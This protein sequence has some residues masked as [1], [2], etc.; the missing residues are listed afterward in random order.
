MS[1]AC[2]ALIADHFTP[3][4]FD[5]FTRRAPPVR[6]TLFL[7][8]YLPSFVLA[9]GTG[10]LVPVLPLYA[11]SFG[12]S[13]GMIGLAL[14][15]QGIGNLIGDIPAGILLGRMGTSAPC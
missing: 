2:R 6:R 7:T 13:Y 1:A 14:A 11:R 10:M 5:K 12:A 15:S 3:L 9:F 8:L 4:N